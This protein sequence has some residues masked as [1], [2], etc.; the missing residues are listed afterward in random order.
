M[1]NSVRKRLEPA[2]LPWPPFPLVWPQNPLLAT[3]GL[4][5]EDI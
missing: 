2:W 1:F 4:I 3:F 5:A